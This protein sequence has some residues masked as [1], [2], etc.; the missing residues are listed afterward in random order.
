[1][2]PPYACGAAYDHPTPYTM[3]Y[4]LNVQRQFGTDWV[5]EV[6]YLGSQSRH[7]Y[8]FQNI[9]QAVPGTSGSIA[10]RVPFPNYGVI[11]LVA[12][13]FNGNYNAGSAKLTRRFGQGLGLTTLLYVV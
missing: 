11:Q 8:G 7:L 5:L 6:G 10:S 9:N 12:D 2:P 1:M 3:Q 4:L 13:G